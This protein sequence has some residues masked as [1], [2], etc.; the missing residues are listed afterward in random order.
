M[1]MLRLSAL[2]AALSLSLT[3]CSQT[4]L[5]PTGTTIPAQTYNYPGAPS[6]SGVVMS[7]PPAA[8]QSV[9]ASVPGL[10]VPADALAVLSLSDEQLGHLQTLSQ[11]LNQATRTYRETLNRHLAAGSSL[12][13]TLQQTFSAAEFNSLDLAPL[14]SQMFS[15]AD[16]QYLTAQTDYL[17][18]AYASLSDEQRNWMID[19]QQ[20]LASQRESQAYL[21]ETFGASEAPPVS[22]SE[23]AA[24]NLLVEQMLSELN[25]SNVDRPQVESLLSQILYGSARE[26]RMLTYLQELH[27]LLTPTQ[28]TDWLNLLKEEPDRL[29]RSL[30]TELGLNFGSARP[31]PLN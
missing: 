31:A 17:L 7:R 12:E 1:S 9:T 28:R 15:E 10:S 16:P 13:Q 14:V 8:A 6:S 26:Q 18:S 11:T 21:A 29:Q 19:I 3:A 5:L 4:G 23:I 24:Q 20:S 27:T 30:G 2:I 25:Q 22:S